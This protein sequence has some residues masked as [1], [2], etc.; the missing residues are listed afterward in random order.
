MLQVHV[1]RERLNKEKFIFDRIRETPGQVL[2]VVPD[3]Y[4]LQA[5]RDAFFYL[6]KPTLTSLEALGIS[7]LADRVLQETGGARRR[8]INRLGRHMLLSAILED[9]GDGLASF[10]NLPDNNAFLEMANDFISGLKQ[11]GVSPEAL[12]ETAARLP[13]ESILAGKLR[14][15]TRIYEAYEA[16]IRGKFTDT[17][18]LMDLV[19]SKVPESAVL[20]ESVLWVFGF[21]NFTPKNLRFLEALAAS[22]RETHLVLTWDKEGPDSDLF[23]LTGGMMSALKPQSVSQIGEEYAVERPASL[24][25]LEQQLFA[26]P[27]TPSAD[28]Q[29]VTLLA[30]ANLYNEAESAAAHVLSLVRD[31]GLRYRDIL[32]VCND[33]ETRG[34]IYRRVFA[35]Y[36]MDL[37]LDAKRPLVHHPLPEFLRAVLD[38]L[39]RQHRTEDVL[40]M[41]K[42][43]FGPLEPGETE[44]LENYVLRYKVRGSRWKKPFDK[45]AMDSS[46]GRTDQERAAA[47][48]RLEAYRKRAIEPVVKLGEAM[49]RA[50]SGRT[51]AEALYRF[52]AEDAGV[53][54]KIETL[55]KAQEERGD[56]EGA[57]TTAQLWNITMELLDQIVEVLGDTRLSMERFAQLLR[58]G[59]DA[60][61]VGLIPPALDGLMMGT[62]QRTR[63]SFVRALMVLGANEGILPAERSGGS[64]LSPEEETLLAEAGMT[65]C[66]S[67]GIRDMEERLAIYRNLSK[68]TE[69]LYVSYAASNEKGEPTRPS[70]IF[71][72]IRSLFPGLE[73]ERDVLTP[74]REIDLVQARDAT[75]RHLTAALRA[76]RGGAP[77]ASPWRETLAWYETREP[78]L[79]AKVRRGLLHNAQPDPL[80]PEIAQGLYLRQEGPLSVSPSRLER[81]GRC[82]F[83]HFVRYGMRPEENRPYEVG[84]VEMGDLYHR[85]L[86]TV[87][88]RLGGLAVVPGS[89]DTPEPGWQDATRADTDRYVREFMD[90]EGAAFAEGILVSDKEQ[91]YRARRMTGVCQLAVWHMVEHLRKGKVQSMHFEEGFGRTGVFAP[92]RIP[93]GGGEVLIEGK[94]DRVDLLPGD[95]VKIIDYKSGQDAFSTREA[96]SGWKLQLMVYLQAALEGTRRP[97]GVFYFHIAEPKIDAGSL[98]AADEAAFREK[99]DEE[100]RRTFRMDGLMVDEPDVVENI[101]GGDPLVVPQS[102]GKGLCSREEFDSLLTQVGENIQRMCK[103]LAGGEIG[104]TPLKVREET[105]CK[106]CDYKSICGFDILLKGCYYTLA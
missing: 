71:D 82:P 70:T 102:R 54:G 15:F 33:L 105:A 6:Q 89:Q 73:V 36:G 85:C 23:Q 13:A 22:A 76:A 61:E 75:L 3:Q 18:D 47:L 72:K 92:I 5:E 103:D 94:I 78:D 7:R 56:L 69:S 106:F 51:R 16:G 98:S 62:M 8:M 35:E 50:A 57:Q 87:S 46:L 93:V 12:G 4:A 104:I 84:P 1:G 48:A 24:K 28:I 34:S 30:A 83:S 58:A 101:S 95:Q 99:L 64:L 44:I 19:I 32:L 53:P 39:G 66:K 81:F 97:A 49:G 79:L 20:R 29:G 2:L 68:A 91:A 60:V 90:T 55:M 59:Y 14:D 11:Y 25:T 42:T 27:G 65:L 41:L 38:I 86:M 74:G 45:G 9:L 77:L 10:R 21:D 100:V 52:L 80:P 63:S 67:D 96:L 37:F 43:G 26:L 17:E 40:S 88:G 31:K